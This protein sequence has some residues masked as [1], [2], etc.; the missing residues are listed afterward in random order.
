MAVGRGGFGLGGDAQ[1]DASAE[2]VADTP[3]A[4]EARWAQKL[5]AVEPEGEAPAVQPSEEPAAKPDV[6]GGMAGAVIP[7]EGDLTR[8]RKELA[9]EEKAQMEKRALAMEKALE[10][11][12]KGSDNSAVVAKDY[13]AWKQSK[14]KYEQVLE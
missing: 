2:L 14:D 1:R 5:Q 12:T 4:F 13:V 10:A 6:L 7:E 8:E 9:G 11:A 3:G